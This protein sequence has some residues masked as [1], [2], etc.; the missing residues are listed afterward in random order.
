MKMVLSGSL[1]ILASAFALMAHASDIEAG[2][3]EL[4]WLNRLTW[5]INRVTITQYHQQGRS[6]WLND[7]LQMSDDQG[8][9]DSVRQRIASMTISTTPMIELIARRRQMEQ[10]INDTSDPDQKAALRQAANL[11]ANELA[12]QAAEREV[13]RDVYSPHQLQELMSWFW[14]NH[15][16]VFRHKGMDNLLIADYEE[17]AI[18]PHA[19]GKFSD[20]VW[21]TLTHPAML[22]YL[23]NQPNAVG[24]SNENYARELM[25]L[26]TLGVN[27]GYTQADVQAL[28]AILTGVGFRMPDHCLP[29]Q[30]RLDQVPANDISTMFCF[31]PARHDDSAKKFLGHDFPARGG[32]AE[33]TRAIELLIRSSATARHISR[34]MA[35]YLLGD[36]P[37]DSVVDAMTRTFQR[38]DGDIAQTLAIL[39]NSEAFR[40]GQYQGKIF[41][42]PMRYVISSVRLLYGNTPIQNVRPVIGWIN[43]LG[44]PLYE[45]VSPE[46]Y[47]LSGQDWLSADQIAKRLDMTKAMYGGNGVLYVDEALTLQLDNTD[48]NKL[49]QLRQHAREEHPVAS[50]DNYDLLRPMLSQQTLMVLDK[51]LD[52]G[53]WNSLLL[54][55]PEFMYR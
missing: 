48:K 45:H 5:G 10:Q 13:L 26:H 24:A 11:Q 40:S 29:G 16:N 42:D 37:P 7:Q 28:A 20:L 47:S 49:Q 55:S 34:E 53:E 15:F 35:V 23:D 12:L 36:T 18:R 6:A 38:S 31:A 22:V 52:M 33:V 19:L 43:Q 8:L 32:K 25:E 27:D 17:H 39:I 1:I 30:N 41:K 4:Q 54:S 14:F 9:P 44:E 46:G 21:A 2:K 51:S 50:F 3:Q